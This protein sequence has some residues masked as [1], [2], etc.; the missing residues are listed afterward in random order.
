MGG[1]R[2]DR[3]LNDRR[4]RVVLDTNFIMLIA[5]NPDVL[6]QIEDKLLLKPEYVVL[7]QVL[8]ELISLAQSKGVNTARKAK[9]ALEIVN[10]FCT[11]VDYV[12]EIKDADE[13]IIKYALENKAI[14][15]TNDR[16]LRRKLRLFGIP[17]IYLRE[18]SMRIDVEG[19]YI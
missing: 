2:G 17:E 13:A 12:N 8:E 6:N 10:R 5:E 4:V 16:E 15:A 7:K 18:E 9:F 19:V 1:Y 14:V 3:G 11:I